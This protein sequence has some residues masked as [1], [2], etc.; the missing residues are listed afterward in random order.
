MTAIVAGS[1]RRPGIEHDEF[2]TAVE[3]SV[4][5]RRTHV[6]Q[7]DESGRHHRADARNLRR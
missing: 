4:R 2:D 5:Y 1:L 6:A 3:Q 7:T